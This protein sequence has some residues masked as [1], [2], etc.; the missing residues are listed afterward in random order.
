MANWSLGPY[1]QILRKIR[2]IFGH[3]SQRAC[4][5]LWRECNCSAALW[6]IFAS[7]VQIQPSLT[8]F[9]LDLNSSSHSKTR[10]L[11]LSR[12]SHGG[13]MKFESTF[14]QIAKLRFS[15]ILADF[16][17][18]YR[19]FKKFSGVEF[20]SQGPEILE[21][22]PS[23]TYLSPCINKIFKIHQKSLLNSNKNRQR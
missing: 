22:S 10:A 3:Q 2:T 21:S 13:P 14:F 4:R 1:P 23:Y 18:N 12:F 17:Q 5:Q 7:S 9:S 6:F 19:I 15:T 16:R 11:Y 20:K 8:M